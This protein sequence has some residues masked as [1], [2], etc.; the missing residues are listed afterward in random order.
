MDGREFEGKNI[1]Q[2]IAEACQAFAVSR[3]KLQIEIM[4]PGNAGFFGIL[5][6]KKA[7]VRA[8]LLSLDL[9]LDGEEKREKAPPERRQPAPLPPAGSTERH[10]PAAAPP[11]QTLASDKASEL[12]SGILRHM[13][14][15]C[16]VTATESQDAIVLT[17]KGNDD[18]FL[19]GKNSQTLDALQ[20]LLNKAIIRSENGKKGILVDFGD[21]RKRQEESLIAMARNLGAR[22]KK[23]GKPVTVD[24]MDAH[25]RRIIHMA[26]RA[27]ES[28]TTISR[29]EG[30]NR[31]IVILPAKNQRSIINDQ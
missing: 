10:P 21:Y 9:Q 29:G 19:I 23:T 13:D 1:D 17:I 14:L 3:D 24:P 22:V 26:L 18:G 2:A 7:A 31:K 16:L 15:Q 12:L 5:G 28:L 4:S 30:K 25:S 8:C 6:V 27:D 11:Q 20:Y